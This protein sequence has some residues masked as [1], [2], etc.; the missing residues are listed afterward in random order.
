M[1]RL[2]TE[3]QNI[4]KRFYHYSQRKKKKRKKK[5]KYLYK[6]RLK[7]SLFF[8][9]TLNIAYMV[10]MACMV[11]FRDGLITSS[12]YVK[13]LFLYTSIT[14]G[15]GFFLLPYKMKHYGFNS[16]NWR[17]N[18]KWG[19]VLGLM[20]SFL[21]V[22]LRIYLVKQGKKE[23]RFTPI[24][25][26]EFYIYPLSVYSQETMT[27]G[28]LQNYFTSLFEK[29]RK[30]QLIAIMLSSAIFAMMHLMY[31]FFLAAMVLIFSI[32]LGYFYK[33]T[34]SIIGVYLIH[35]MVGT[36]MFYFKL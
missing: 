4:T 36:T 34:Y 31:G 29:T 18:L 16:R 6:N 22:L 30:N 26:W 12:L 27:R 7:E 33:K 32:A 23:F 14:V 15:F 24:P 21:A 25:E 9:V 13:F 28:F 1:L 35:F 17:F 2:L 3:I 8:M 19:L 11:L 20:G 10:S 5:K